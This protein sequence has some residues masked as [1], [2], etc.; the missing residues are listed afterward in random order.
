M[1]LVNPV[2]LTFGFCLEIGCA[3]R[4]ASLSPVGGAGARSRVIGGPRSRSGTNCVLAVVV[5]NGQATGGN[6]ARLYRDSQGHRA[7]PVA[8]CGS[9][10]SI[11][12][13]GWP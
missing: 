6:T 12:G 5:E 8:L 2:A 4:H 9:R 1:E 11:T 10:R 3:A 13:F 7:T